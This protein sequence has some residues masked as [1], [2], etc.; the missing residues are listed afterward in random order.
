MKDFNL[1]ALLNNTERKDCRKFLV[2]D[3]KA[4]RFENARFIVSRPI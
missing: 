2:L 1:K 3:N 4:V